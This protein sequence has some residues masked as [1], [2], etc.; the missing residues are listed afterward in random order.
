VTARWSFHGHAIVSADDC[1]AD[2]ASA[3]PEGLRNAADWAL[4]QAEL[5]ATALVILGRLSHE[6]APNRAGRRR[7]VM[8]GSGP[9]LDERDGA[10]WWN[11]AR[12]DLGALLARL[13]PQGGRVGVPGG[14]RV[15]DFFL[16]RGFAT[17]HLSR[18]PGLVLPGGRRLFAGAGT[19][20]ERLADAGLRPGPARVIDPGPPVTL[21]VWTSREAL[22]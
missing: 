11:P 8:T 21:T 18:V 6:A 2:A 22:P 13:L 14:Q 10:F 1:I 15:F 9:G 5:D 12:L 7:V 3:M 20:E 4:F 19:A 16:A 17:F